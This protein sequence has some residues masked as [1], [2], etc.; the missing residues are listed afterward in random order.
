[1][2]KDDL[3]MMINPLDWPR[4]PLLPIKRRRAHDWETAVLYADKGTVKDG[5]PTIIKNFNIFEPAKEATT[6]SEAF[7]GHEKQTYNSFDELLADGWRV[8]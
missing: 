2:S 1:M 8:D 6:W 7:K 5:K 3:E 4:W